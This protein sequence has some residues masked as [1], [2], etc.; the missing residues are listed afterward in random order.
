VIFAFLDWKSEI[1]RRI[2][3]FTG[4]GILLAGAPELLNRLRGA[5]SELGQIYSRV[6]ISKEI[7][8]LHMEDIKAIL[9]INFPEAIESTS[10]IADKC[11]LTFEKKIFMPEV[12]VKTVISIEEMIIET[13]PSILSSGVDAKFIQS[14]IKGKDNDK[15]IPANLSV[16]SNQHGIQLENSESFKFVVSK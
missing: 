16:H 6:G 5:R 9:K 13:P 14:V 8:L 3:D 10:E 7:H 1:I 4:V 2:Q 11:D 12:E 15:V